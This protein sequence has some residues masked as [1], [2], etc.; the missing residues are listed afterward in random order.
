[1]SA[2]DLPPE[3]VD[4][5]GGYDLAFLVSIGDLGPHTTPHHPVLDTNRFRI[6]APG[7]V[8]CRNITA[9]PAVTLLWPP[10]TPTGHVL[11]IDG[12][13]ALDD[14]FTLEVVPTQAVLHHT[15]TAGAMSR[16]CG[17][18]RRF[19]LA[20]PYMLGRTNRLPHGTGR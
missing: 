5:I 19:N 20:P 7:P 2:Q 17:D 4:I 12:H 11:I 13:A 3:L 1:M 6:P 15:G 14:D 10:A 8:T 16:R 9:N 18:C